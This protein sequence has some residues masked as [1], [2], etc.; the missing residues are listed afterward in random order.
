MKGKQFLYIVIATFITI[1]VWVTLDLI[2]TRSQV[3]PSPD[4]EKLLEPID[5]QFDQETINDL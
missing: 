2:H 5:P 1:V 3:Q 4:I